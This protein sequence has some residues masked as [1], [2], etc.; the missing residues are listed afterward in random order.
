MSFVLQ[1]RCVVV[2]IVHLMRGDVR[3]VLG[4]NRFRRGFVRLRHSLG[5]QPVSGCRI[6][7]GLHRIHVVLRK[8]LGNKIHLK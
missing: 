7:I 3:R 4:V 5:L 8:V 2:L 1:E 6:H